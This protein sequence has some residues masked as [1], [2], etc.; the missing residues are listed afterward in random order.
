[1]TLDLSKLNIVPSIVD[2]EYENRQ[3]TFQTIMSG[4][5]SINCF[6]RLF[7]FSNVFQIK[8]CLHCK[9]ILSQSIIVFPRFA[10]GAA[11][12]KLIFLPPLYPGQMRLFIDVQAGSFCES[13]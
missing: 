12:K 2:Y 10:K 7:R 5:L 1:M 8:I 11:F 4:D 13:E 6:W 3:P 9:S